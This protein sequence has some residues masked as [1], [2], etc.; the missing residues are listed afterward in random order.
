M[1][2]IQI[3]GPIDSATINTIEEE[4]EI[5]NAAATSE[6][7]QTT[8]DV[9]ELTLCN[10]NTATEVEA[11]K[12]ETTDETEVAE[13][14]EASDEC[15]KAECKDKSSFEKFKQYIPCSKEKEQAETTEV[16]DETKAEETTEEVAP[17]TAKEAAPAEKKEEAEEANEETNTD[18]TADKT[19]EEAKKSFG[20]KIKSGIT[21]F[22]NKL[23]CS[24]KEEATT[25]ATT[26]DKAED[27]AEDSSTSENADAPATDADAKAE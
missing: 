16:Q 14:G 18:D 22:F 2:D 3:N 21:S 12:A 19:N 7:A 27:K 9:A 25:E 23:P 6:E 15:D 13:E 24:K 4:N 20:D 17:E 11:P 26:E 1:S 8:N 10:E 5:N